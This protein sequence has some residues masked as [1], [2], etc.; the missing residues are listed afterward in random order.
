MTKNWHAM[1]IF[2]AVA[3]SVLTIG[4]AHAHDRDHPELNGWY[5]TLHSGKGPCCDG[6]EAKRVDDADWEIAND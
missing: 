4:S 1:V 6:S 2:A 5:E 3:L